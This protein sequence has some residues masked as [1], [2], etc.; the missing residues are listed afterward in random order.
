MQQQLPQLFVLC[1]RLPDS[2]ETI[3]HQQTQNMLRIPLVGL[4]LAH[5]AGSDLAGIAQH[6]LVPLSFGQT[7]EPAVVACSLHPDPHWQPGQSAVKRFGFAP[8]L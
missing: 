6:K 4:L 3:R 7:A 5:A 1:R 8:M 2:G